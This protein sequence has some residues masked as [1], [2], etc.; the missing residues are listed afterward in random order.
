MITVLLEHKKRKPKVASHPDYHVSKERQ[1]SNIRYSLTHRKTKEHA[2]SLDGYY[3]RRDRAFH[4]D[5]VR[6]QGA[7]RVQSKAAEDARKS[8]KHFMPKDAVS[9]VLKHV[10]KDFPGALHI[11]A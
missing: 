3:D 10:K 5:M 1:G 2:G 8:G 7:G 9:H 4:V 6:A 11:H